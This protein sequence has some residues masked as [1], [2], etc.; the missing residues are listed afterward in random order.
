MPVAEQA[1]EVLEFD[2]LGGRTVR[3]C[4]P[5]KAMILLLATECLFLVNLLLRMPVSEE[6]EELIQEAAKVL[7]FTRSALRNDGG[8]SLAGEE[9]IEQHHSA[10]AR[11]GIVVHGLDD[12]QAVVRVKCRH[13][14]TRQK[15]VL[16]QRQ[17]ACNSLGR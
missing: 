8:K 2:Q 14:R 3:I 11:C 6:F 5:G 7:G 12:L 9:L 17:M 13:D 4:T 10:K 16:Q 15:A 1:S